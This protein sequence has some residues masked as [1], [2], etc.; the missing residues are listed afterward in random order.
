MVLYSC[1]PFPPLWCSNHLLDDASF[2]GLVQHIATEPSTLSV[3]LDVSVPVLSRHIV[4]AHYT[5]GH[6][7]QSTNAP[8]DVVQYTVSALDQSGNP[9]GGI[10]R[11]EDDQLED[12]RLRN[13]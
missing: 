3:V 6:M 11:L 4:T 1:S 10:W 13:V 12:V 5:C 8:G 9:R 7:Q 2:N